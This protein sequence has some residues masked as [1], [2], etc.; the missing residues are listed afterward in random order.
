MKLENED[1]ITLYTNMVLARG[2][3]LLAGVHLID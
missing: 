3:V 2:H 1:L